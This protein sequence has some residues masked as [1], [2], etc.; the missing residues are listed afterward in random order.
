MCKHLFEKKTLSSFK[1]HSREGQGTGIKPDG[2]MTFY[3][4]ISFFFQNFKKRIGFNFQNF[5]FLF[6]LQVID[7]T[8]GGMTTRVVVRQRGNHKN[9]HISF[10]VLRWLFLHSYIAFQII[11]HVVLATGAV[12]LTFYSLM[13]DERWKNLRSHLMA[14]NVLGITNTTFVF[15]LLLTLVCPILSIFQ[16][17]LFSLTIN[18]KSLTK[19]NLLK[20]I[21][22][23]YHKFYKDW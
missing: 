7:I 10:F 13:I 4:F 21:V 2:S 6:K 18:Y 1:R 22:K 8:I 17:L 3:R 16:T 11:I 5:E 14:E 12:Y 20:I 15:G 9:T 23:L 19:T